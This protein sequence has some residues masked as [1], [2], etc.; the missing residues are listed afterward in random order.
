LDQIADD[1]STYHFNFALHAGDVAYAGTGAEWEI[2][3]VW[4]VY[5]DLLQPVAANIPYMFSVGNH[6]KYYN[7]TSFKT[8]Y[9]MPSNGNGN[10]WYSFDYGSAH[11]TYMSTEHDY[12]PK[13]AQY[14][15]LVNDLSSAASRNDI[16]WIIMSG[17]RPMYNSDTA[18]WDQHRP[19]APF[20]QII[21]PLM[22]KYNVNLYL[23]GN[24]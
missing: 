13:S 14:Q 8:R 21:E 9:T 10:F 5:G 20:Q 2:E 12:T 15:W 6:E 24:I 22:V 11:Y 18:E 23:C 1:H 3:E 19:G 7:F 17:H 4:D 16:N